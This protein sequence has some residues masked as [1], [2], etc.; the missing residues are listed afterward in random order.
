MAGVNDSAVE[1]DSW[2]DG[3]GKRRMEAEP[4]TGALAP[5]MRVACAKAT[6]PGP[7]LERTTE[8]ASAA[9][10]SLRPMVIHERGAITSIG[11][12]RIGPLSSV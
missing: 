5:E 12:T 4:P 8:A 7:E 11:Y 9:A 1:G 6:A 10:I 2:A 3:A